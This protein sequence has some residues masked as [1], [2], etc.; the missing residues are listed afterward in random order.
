VMGPQG[1]V[2]TH[3]DHPVEAGVWDAPPPHSFVFEDIKYK[4]HACCHGTHAMI[5]GL[6]TALRQHNLTPERVA[7]LHLR[8]SPRWLSVCDIK[9]PRTGLEVKFSYA[10]LAGMVLAGIP[11]AAERTYTDALAVDPTLGKFAEKITVSGSPNVGDMQAEGEI[12]LTDG[13]LLPFGHDLAARIDSAV[14]EASLR[15][16]AFGLLGGAAERLWDMVANLPALGAA[17]LGLG[18]RS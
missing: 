17:D 3:S 18:L 15:A 4:L 9:R 11:T 14:L 10:W 2:L 5:E 16:K 7:N 6:A 13:T 8:T 1:F 12:L